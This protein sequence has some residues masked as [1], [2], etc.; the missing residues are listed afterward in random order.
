VGKWQRRAKRKATKTANGGA[1]RSMLGALYLLVHVS[2]VVY[3]ECCGLVSVL[4]FSCHQSAVHD[5]EW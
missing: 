3:V 2:V 5:R 1:Q 4:C